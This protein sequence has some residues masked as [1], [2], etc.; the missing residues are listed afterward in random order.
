MHV[1]HNG[2][3]GF[4]FSGIKYEVVDYIFPAKGGTC[5]YGKLGFLCWIQIDQLGVVLA[6]RRK[7]RKDFQV[8]WDHTYGKF[9]T[10]M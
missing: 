6:S 3:S 4:L 8:C 2:V 1:Y 10:A 5:L 9:V 7:G